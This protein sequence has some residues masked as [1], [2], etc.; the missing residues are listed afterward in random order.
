M[1]T[2]G[3]WLIKA[4]RCFDISVSSFKTKKQKNNN[5]HQKLINTAKK[6]N[7]TEIMTKDERTQIA[8]GSSIYVFIRLDKLLILNKVCILGKDALA[9]IF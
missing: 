6:V 8:F 9:L 3:L 7:A 1:L 5:N 2:K 4:V